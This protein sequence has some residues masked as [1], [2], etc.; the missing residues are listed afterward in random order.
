MLGLFV[1]LAQAVAPAQGWAQ[2][3]APSA[4]VSQPSPPPS[5]VPGPTPQE[6]S[7]RRISVDIESTKPATVLER[8]ISLTET[9]GAYLLLPYHST[10][11]VWEQVCVT[12]CQVDLDRFSSYRVGKLNGVLESRSFTLPQA[13]DRFQLRI[14]PGNPVPHRVGIAMSAIGA[15]A[16]ITGVGL[17]AGEKIFRDE[18]A[19]RNAGFISG[20]AGVALLAIGI[21]L[22]VLTSTKVFGLGGRMALSPRG[23]LF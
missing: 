10:E 8:R 4:T 14:E 19:A 3:V 1:F 23:L 21:P 2:D 17:V 16:L 13:A 15:A 12:P 5:P 11:A 22:T 20:G 18:E 7:R 6:V 9:D